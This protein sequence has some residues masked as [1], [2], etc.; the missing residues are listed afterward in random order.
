MRYSAAM[1][2]YIGLFLFFAALCL[3]RPAAAQTGFGGGGAGGITSGA[4]KA[5]RPEASHEPAP[6]PA[7]PGA[8]ARADSVTP[9]DRGAADL[10]PTEALF[11]AINRGDITSA[12]DAITRGAD[13]DA[14]N[15][16]GLTP[17]EL[18]VDLGRND[19]TFLL[20]SLRGATGGQRGPVQTAD[21]PPPTDRRTKQRP[22]PRN[23]STAEQA[24]LAVPTKAAPRN[25]ALFAGNGGA[26]VPSVGFLGFE[27]HQ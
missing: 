19:I 5:P 11:D 25:P 22:M 15:L 12:R 9:V 17:T 27:P 26:P 21:A 10:P 16:L 3:A 4:P 24:A 18:S 20:L 13:L 1:R 8:K 14:T 7:V 23:P 2:G 6:P